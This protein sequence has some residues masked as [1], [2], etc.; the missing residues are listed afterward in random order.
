MSKETVMNRM[1]LD[2][3]LTLFESTVIPTLLDMVVKHG[4][5]AKQ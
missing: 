2:P 3:Q 5:Q 1:S 4:H